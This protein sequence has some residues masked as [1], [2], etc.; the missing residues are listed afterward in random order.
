M[1]NSVGAVLI[2]AGYDVVFA[3]DVT[4]P[5][6]ADDLVCAVAEVNEC[7]LVSFDKDMRNAAR[8][9][10]LGGRARFPFLS[11]IKLCCYEPEAADRLGSALSLIEHEWA[12]RATNEGRRMY[13]EI[14][15]T[16][17]RVNR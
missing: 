12:R 6:A 4:G 5:G 16:V 3:R 10:G 2:G 11:L 17:I 13:I 7:I 15:T 9:Q 1:P 8:R 14:G